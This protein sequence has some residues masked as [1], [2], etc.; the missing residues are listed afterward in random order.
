MRRGEDGFTLIEL[1]VAMMLLAIGILS[2]VGVLDMARKL[3]LVAER[4]TSLTHRAQQELERVTSLPYGQIA[5]TS[6]PGHSADTS[7]PD[8][9]VSGSDF[10]YDRGSS[11]TTEPLVVDPGGTITPSGTDGSTGTWTD[12][13]LSGKIYTFVT[14]HYDSVCGT[15][16]TALCSTS[17]DYKRVTIMLTLNGATHPSRPVLVSTFVADP[18]SSPN[19]YTSGVNNPLR[20]PDGKCLDSGGNPVSCTGGLD[21]G[22]PITYF[23]SDSPYN[24]SYQPPS[25]GNNVHQTVVN[26]LC[27]VLTCPPQPD[28]LITSPP[29][30][31]GTQPPCYSLDLGCVLSGGS[32]TGLTLKHPPTDGTCGT[33]PSDN[34]KTHSWVTPAIPAGTTVN[35]TGHGGMTAYVESASG[36]AVNVKVC[37]GLYIVPGG[38][39]GVLTG[40]LLGSRIG[41]AASA[42]VQ[43]AAGVPTPVSFQFNVGQAAQISSNVSNIARIE[44]VVWLA[45]SAGTDVALVYDHPQF[46]SQVELMAQ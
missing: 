7:N 6:A 32:G 30:T 1:L 21:T 46:A 28:Q 25:S 14:W 2:L 24:G 9:Y 33:P 39:L 15:G 42:D 36:V 10:Q 23:L 4:Q 12:G 13:R 37:V 31:G 43:A 38:V 3:T 35:L 22:T 40:N 17:H 19:G 16:S 41:V 34:T 5:L 8:Y 45:A 27:G 20:S 29:T 11:T 44:V 26:F 18:R